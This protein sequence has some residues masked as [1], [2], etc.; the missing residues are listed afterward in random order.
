MVERRRL[1]QGRRALRRRRL[2]A[3]EDADRTSR[4]PRRSGDAALRSGRPR[5]PRRPRA[6]GVDLR[7]RARAARARAGRRR[8]ALDEI[9][10]AGRRQP[11]AR[12]WC[13]RGWRRAARAAARASRRRSAAYPP[14]AWDPYDDLVRGTRLRGLGLLL[15]PTT[16][17]AAWASRCRPR[18]PACKPVTAR[19]PGVRDARSGGATRAPTRTR[20]RAAG[21]CRACARWSLLNEPNQPAWLTPQYERR[22]G[23][24]VRRAAVALP[25]AGA[26][27]D[28]GAAGERARARPD[29]ARRD[30]ADRAHV[31]V[32]GA[33]ADAA[34]GVPADAVLPR[35]ARQARCGALRRAG[36]GAG[37]FG[38]L[39]VAG[40]AH[41]PYPRGGSRPPASPP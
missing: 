4:R 27:R 32:A 2:T 9:E 14:A 25:G 18:R 30:V 28:R 10:R 39:A 37:R 16:P 38:R 3:A 8:A 15:S 34:G 22:R 12:S 41:H 26:G 40:F 24:R 23:R 35:P 31:G 33:A 36:A 7:G 21:C 20:T 19:L 6:P 5:P 17:M 1:G 11:C 13:G 29:A